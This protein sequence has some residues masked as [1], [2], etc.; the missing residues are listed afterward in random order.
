M[1]RRVVKPVI[2]PDQVLPPLHLAYRPAKLSEVVGQAHVVQ[3][4]EKLA[5]KANAPHAYLFTGPSGT[6]KTSLARILATKFDAEIIEIDAATNSG[7][8]AI[9]DVTASLRY[10]GLGASRNKFMIIDE[11]HA[12]SKQAWQSLLK[13]I[14]EPPQHVYFVLCT[15]EAGKVPSTIEGR[16][17]SFM[18]QPIDYEDVLDA[19]ERITEEEKLSVPSTVNQMIAQACKGS[20]RVALVRLQALDGC[21][22]DQARILLEQPLENREIIDLCRFLLQD[23]APSWGAV[24]K[25]L[26]GLNDPP[27][28]IRIVVTNYTSGCLMNA[29]NDKEAT[30]LLNILEAF[31]VPCNPTDK[32][33]PI[34]IAFGRIVFP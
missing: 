21:G 30:R 28:S 22:E 1:T 25:T 8:D 7:I 26:K 16:C 13:M 18:L 4:L 34:L 23:K 15:T 11:A 32:L 24:V 14:E 27:E 6:G 5:A 17:A 29:R 19:L 20:M 10:A 31:S 12:L 9:K 3:A 33:A 2:Q